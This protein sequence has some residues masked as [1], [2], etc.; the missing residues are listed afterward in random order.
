VRTDIVGWGSAAA[1]RLLA[2]VDRD[3]AGDEA[4]SEVALPAPEFVI[5]ASTAPP[6]R[7][8]NGAHHKDRRG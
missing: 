5:R 6:C 7:P 1:T 3:A 2:I 4:G 8:G